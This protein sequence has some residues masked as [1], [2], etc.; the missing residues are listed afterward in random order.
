M[1]VDLQP[2]PALTYTTLGGII[3]LYVFTGPTVENV[4][5]QYWDIIGVKFMT[6]D[7]FFRAYS[8]F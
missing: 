6:Q 5:E 2:L 1:E 3:D 7:L 4:V 8:L